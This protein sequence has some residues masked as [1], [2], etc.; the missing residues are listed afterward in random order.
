NMVGVAPGIAAGVANNGG[1]TPTIALLSGS[2]A[3]D[4]GANSISGVQVPTIDQRGAVRG[5]AGLNAGASVDIGGYEASSIYLVSTTDD[6][7]NA[8][9]LRTGVG[10]ANLSTNVNPAT[11][12]SPAPNTVFFSAT[13]TI[14]L[15]GGTLALANSGGTNVAKSLQGPGP[16]LLSISG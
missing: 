6:T 14:N 10:W 1:P 9:P 4:G 13:G 12:F 16:G 11:L 2:P 7:M 5:P 15:T 3:I 8:G